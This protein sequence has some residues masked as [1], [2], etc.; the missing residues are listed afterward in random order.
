[1]ITMDI[2]L[3]AQCSKTADF[4]SHELRSTDIVVRWGG[5]EY[6]VIVMD[7]S[8]QDLEKIAGR[9]QKNRRFLLYFFRV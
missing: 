8:A 4:L 3:V 7:I 9:I 2:L 5:D 6:A 1:M